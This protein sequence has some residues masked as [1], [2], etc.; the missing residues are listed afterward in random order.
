MSYSLSETSQLRLG[1]CH[2]DLHLIILEAIKY[3]PIDFGVS[4]GHRTPEEQNK[5]YQQGRTK[6]GQIVTYLDGYKKKSKHNE[7]PSLAVDI[8]CWPRKVMYDMNHLCTVGGVII[9]TAA[10]LYNEGR[11]THKLVWGNDWNKNGILVPK[12]GSERMIDAPHFEII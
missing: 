5:L 6:P 10:R 7:S 11:I 12:D 2:P 1:T 4:H 8:Y 3:S 9:A